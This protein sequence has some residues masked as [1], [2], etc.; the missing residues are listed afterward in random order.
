MIIS[1][2]V[3]WNVMLCNPVLGHQHFREI[4]QTNKAS[5]QKVVILSQKNA[6]KNLRQE[7]LI[8]AGKI[9]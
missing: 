9:W 4:Y 7:N 5:S 8:E 6:M 1:T 2:T 3:F